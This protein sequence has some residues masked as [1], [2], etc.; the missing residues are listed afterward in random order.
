MFY[1]YFRSLTNQEFAL[2]RYWL[3]LLLGLTLVGL[4]AGAALYDLGWRRAL[5]G[6]A[7]PF[8]FGTKG[9]AANFLD[10]LKTPADWL[11]Y[12]LMLGYGPIQPGANAA[13][14]HWHGHGPEQA[15]QRKHNQRHAHPMHQLVGG[16]L[17]AFAVFGQEGGERGHGKSGGL[18]VLEGHSN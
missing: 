8:H 17:V 3:H 11:G 2:R 13:D 6:Q 7:L 12:A 14:G 16:V 18:L 15:E 5:H 1:L 4:H 10:F 9:V